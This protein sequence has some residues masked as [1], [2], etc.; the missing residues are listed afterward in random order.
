MEINKDYIERI[1]ARKKERKWQ[2]HYWQQQA[3]DC[4]DSLGDK[5]YG[6]YLRLFKKY[7]VDKLL[8][9]R[10][11]V[12]KNAKKPDKNRGKLFTAVYKKFLEPPKDQ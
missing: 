11:W 2:A 9:C 8:R 7:G 5:N 12:L 4:A 10:D 1:K 6:V 3:V